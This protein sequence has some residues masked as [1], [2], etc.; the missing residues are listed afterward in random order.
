MAEAHDVLRRPIRRRAMLA[1]LLAGG[2]SGPLLLSTPARAA[3]PVGARRVAF[4]ADPSKQMTVSFSA[5]SSFQSA[6]VAYGTDGSFG[7]TVAADA[8]GVA[9]SAMRYG[10]AALDG[11]SAD[12]TYSYQVRL[13]GQASST[14]TFRT[15]PSQHR[16]FTFTAFADQGVTVAAAQAIKRIQAVKPSFHLLAGDLCYADTTGLGLPADSLQPSIWDDWLNLVEPLAAD[17][18]FMQAAGNHEM[19]PGMGSLG[20]GGLLARMSFPGNGPAACP[21]AYSFRYSNVGV[22][23]L[24]SNDASYEIPANFGYSKG[25]QATWLERTLAAMRTAGSGVDFVVAFF[26]HCPY[27][28]NGA[29]GSEGGVREAWVKL[30]DKYQVDLVLTGHNHCYERTRPIRGGRGVD[31]DAK[32]VDSSAGTTYLTVGGGGRDINATFLANS[33][34]T[35]VSDAPKRNSVEDVDW[36]YLQSPTHSYVTIDVTP[37][38]A[39]QPA[40]MAVSAIRTEDGQQLDS[41]VLS[42]ANGSPTQQLSVGSDPS[43]AQPLLIGGGTAAAVAAVGALAWRSRKRDDQT[44]W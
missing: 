32:A 7:S 38:T 33:T 10:H 15:A 18:P 14:G 17:V 16:P 4:G 2:V 27:A 21:T 31:G 25:S 12:T 1:A 5:A 23:A 43:I 20:Y 39:G 19:E 22:I 30:F 3:A 8:T 37:A 26:H 35:R 29:H 24:D 44:Q 40:S 13:D 34:K 36:S 11:L 28:T 6:T 9:G 42:R 41:F